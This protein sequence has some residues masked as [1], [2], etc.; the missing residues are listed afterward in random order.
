MELNCNGDVIEWRFNGRPLLNSAGKTQLTITNIKPTHNG[1][2]ECISTRNSLPFIRWDSINSI[3]RYPI[4]QAS[5][6]KTVKCGNTVTLQCCSNS[7]DYEVVMQVD[8]V[9][10]QE[11]GSP[12]SCLYSYSM[13][14]C[15]DRPKQAVFTCKITNPR[16]QN[17]AYSSRTTTSTFTDEE[18]DC[19]DETFGAG[20]VGDRGEGNCEVDEVGRVTAVC[21]GT[22]WE[23]TEG[24][25]V[26]RV[27]S[28]LEDESQTL[29]AETL[30]GFV[31]KLSIITVE[32]EAQITNS[33]G[34]IKSL[35]NTLRNVAL[36]SQNFTISVDVIE[37]FFNATSIIVSNS[38]TRV[39]ESLND[40]NTTRN[41][42][43]S[44]LRAAENIVGSLQKDTPFETGTAIIQIRQTINTT[45]N[46]TLQADSS[47]TISIPEEGNF[48]VTTVAFSTGYI[49]LPA[50]NSSDSDD[51]YNSSFTYNFTRNSVDNSTNNSTNNTTNSSTNNI[52]ATVVLVQVNVT[53]NNI[54]LSFDLINETAGNPQCVFWN[55]DLFDGLGGWDSFGCELISHINNTVTCEC[56]HTTSFSILMSP[57]IPPGLK[58]LLDFI[59]YIGVGISLASLIICLII[60]GIIWKSMTRNDTSYMRHV[61]VVNVAVSLL[62]A[63]IWFIVGAAVSD[64]EETSVGSCTAATFFIHFFY[65]ALFF[66]MLVSALLLFYRTVMVLSHMT[67][68]TMLAIAFTLGYG[69][70]LIIAV[71]TVATT[72]GSG[73]YIRENK[74]CWL[75]WDKTK[76]LLAFVIPALTIVAINFLVMI[77]VL[78]KMLRRGVGNTNQ[79]NDKH[80]LVVIARCVAILTPLFGL[81]WGFGIGIMVWPE[82]AGLHIV[83]AVL[84]SLQGLFVLVFG[85]L[86]DSKVSA[87]R[88]NIY[89]FKTII[90]I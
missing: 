34:N 42:S 32:N 69:A 62:I 70:P 78:F 35:V 41:V 40:G 73:G 27:I 11:H 67:R 17:F 24:T 89:C 39:W 37:D 13:Q 57:Y 14:N 54:S 3:K 43:V 47:T 68:S 36:A 18:F 12:Q 46:E 64:S 6:N 49:F 2:Y 59:T 58:L 51:T 26:L 33:T 15:E 29:S 31:E 76:A 52:T 63:D 22:A 48:T 25:C 71:V 61:C 44:L 38:T 65:L 50:R 8:D 19:S 79:S 21:Q 9:N 80:A 90:W 87:D 28:Q 86:L 77:V 30:P 16:L 81:T 85:T 23:R 1:R 75:N 60:E 20:N 53:I 4:I 82:A 7:E 55:F 83:F 84:N 10:I 72:A 74:I 45:A 56:N 5:G 88:F 66:W